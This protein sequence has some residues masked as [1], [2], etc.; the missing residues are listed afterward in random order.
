MRKQYIQINYN[1]IIAFGLFLRKKKKKTK[2]IY[3]L[4][5]KTLLEEFMCFSESQLLLDLILLT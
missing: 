3:A 1:L 4:M 2:Y 5:W